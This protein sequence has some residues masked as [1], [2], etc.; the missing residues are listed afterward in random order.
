MSRAVGESR[1]RL[2]LMHV[3]VTSGKYVNSG[4]LVRAMSKAASQFARGTGVAE[5][6]VVFVDGRP[7]ARQASP[8]SLPIFRVLAPCYIRSV[9]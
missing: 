6:P 2:D 8:A 4:F 5:P 3:P 7:S 1:E 9:K